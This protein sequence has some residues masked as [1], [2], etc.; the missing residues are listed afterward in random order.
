MIGI[1]LLTKITRARG[2]IFQFPRYHDSIYI[3][4][5]D[6][7]YENCHGPWGKAAIIFFLV[8]MALPMAWGTGNHGH[9]DMRK[10]IPLVILTMHMH[11]VLFLLLDKLFLYSTCVSHMLMELFPL[12]ITS[13][14]I[15]IL[16][17]QVSV[18]VSA[19]I[20]K[21]LN[22]VS[23]RLI[24]LPII[25]CAGYIIRAYRSGNLMFV[26]ASNL[27]IHTRNCTSPLPCQFVRR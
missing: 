21:C 24:Q 7:L 6:L 1:N 2:I 19:I 22:V 25:Y 3:P 8:V 12:L 14:H 5:D 20:G 27:E 26:L 4:A 15:G 16:G 11:L 17:I 9:T 18:S 10:G 13:T 23:V